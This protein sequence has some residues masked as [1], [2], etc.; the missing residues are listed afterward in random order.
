[1]FTSHW[2]IDLLSAFHRL[3]RPQLCIVLLSAEVFEHLTASQPPLAFRGRSCPLFVM[4]LR[5][6]EDAPR[7]ARTQKD[8][9]TGSRRRHE[10]KAHAARPSPVLIDRLIPKKISKTLVGPPPVVPDGLFVLWSNQIYFK[11]TRATLI[12]EG[13]SFSISTLSSA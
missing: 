2:L 1:M 6:P 3:Q 8:R 10:S 4:Q 12:F 9:S 7:C 11:A 13:L 5:Q